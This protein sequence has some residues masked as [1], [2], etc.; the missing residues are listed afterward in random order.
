MHI[1]TFRIKI[2]YDVNAKTHYV[3]VFNICNFVLRNK[4]E[5]T[6]NSGKI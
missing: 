6:K 2:L 1:T 5:E 3:Q 4:R